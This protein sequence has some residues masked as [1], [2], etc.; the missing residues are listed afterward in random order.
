MPICG[1]SAKRDTDTM[2]TFIDSSWYFFRYTDPKNE[3]LIFDHNK[4]S[5]AIPIDLYIGGVEHAILHLLYSRFVSK[6]LGDCGLWSGEQFSNE[7]IKRLVTQGM[8]Q[9]KTFTDPTTGRFL[10]PDEVDLKSSSGPLI[11]A[12]GETPNY[13]GVDPTTLIETYGID[14]VRAQILFAAPVSDALNW[15][16]DHILGIQRW[17]RKVI[18]MKDD[19]L[20]KASA[21]YHQDSHADEFKNVTING[22]QLESVKL[23]KNETSLFNETQ[24]YANRIAQSIGTDLS[25]NTVISDYMKLTNYL[26]QVLKRRPKYHAKPFDRLVQKAFDNY[27]SSDTLRCRRVL[28]RSSFGFRAGVEID[29]LANLSHRAYAYSTLQGLQNHRQW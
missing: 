2:D 26:Q 24:F 23:T 27:G 4:A 16:E 12:T 28:G 7:P 3:S 19:V 20:A 1:S 29:L 25:M 14:A 5:A 22:E 11:K 21:Q 8:V 15:N 6:F 10:T 13:N 9:G 17:L 18:A